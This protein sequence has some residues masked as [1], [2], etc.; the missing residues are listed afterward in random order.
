MIKIM[1]KKKMEIIRRNIEMRAAED[2]NSRMIEGVAVVFD[3]WSRDLGGFKEIIRSSAISEDLVNSS[4]VIANI[5]HDDN[6][7]VAR[8]KRG[9]GTLNLEL[10]EDGLHFSFEAPRTSR[11]D[12]LLWNI[13]H[14]NL[15]ECSFAFTLPNNS[16][17]QRWFR[18]EDGSLK[19]EIFEIGG[20]YDVSVVTLAAYSE[21]SVDSRNVEVIDTELIIR[22]LDE[23]EEEEKKKEEEV[24]IGEI[25]AKLDEKLSNFYKN[26]RI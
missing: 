5:N 7:M 15:D 14:G 26:I 12:E 20:L 24:R 1:K 21:T 19:R 23:K 10:K 18:D 16:S 13:R 11:G 2:E 4:D 22:N 25:H 6:Q 9:K 3:S 17:C 8:W